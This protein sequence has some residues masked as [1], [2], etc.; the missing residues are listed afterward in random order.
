MRPI[1]PINFIG[2]AAPAALLFQ[3]GTMDKLIPQTDARRY[4]QAASQ[5]KQIR[6]Y[7]AGHELNCTAHKDMMAWL[8][9]HIRIDPSRYRCQP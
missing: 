3:A 1:E 2:Q 8:A 9:G 4:Q 6:W 5:P 7:A